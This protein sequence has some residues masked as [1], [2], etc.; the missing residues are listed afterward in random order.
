MSRSNRCPVFPGP[1]PRGQAQIPESLTPPPKHRSHR[2][3]CG[4]RLM[5]GGRSPWL[6]HL[7]P[8]KASQ[9]P[10]PRE[11]HSTGRNSFRCFTDRCS[12]PP[13]LLLFPPSRLTH[14]PARL[15]HGLGPLL[16]PLP[17][18][19]VETLAEALELG[20]FS[21]TFPAPSQPHP[22]DPKATPAGENSHSF[23][24]PGQS[25]GPFLSASAWGVKCKTSA[26]KRPSVGQA[27]CILMQC[28]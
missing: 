28:F 3:C 26:L 7:P 6:C 14:S 24:T 12:L 18:G 9:F 16:Q 25:R 22:A 21:P 19:S 15:H 1:R 17:L 2:P 11:P 27:N 5:E 4:V 8:F 10:F 23:P 20:Y 13:S